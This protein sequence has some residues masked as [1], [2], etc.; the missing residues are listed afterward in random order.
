M[1][2]IENVRGVV[3]DTKRD[4]G[5]WLLQAHSPTGRLFI[6]APALLLLLAAEVLSWRRDRR[7]DPAITPLVRSLG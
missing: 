7:E 4:W 6:F 1:V 2:R 5:R 3:I